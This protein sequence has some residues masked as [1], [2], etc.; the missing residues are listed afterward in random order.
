MDNVLVDSFVF[1]CCFCFFL[2][3]VVANNNKAW[4]GHTLHH[5]DMRTATSPGQWQQWTAVSSL[6]GLISEG[7][8]MWL[9]HIPTR[10]WYFS[11]A[12]VFSGANMK[13]PP[14]VNYIQVIPQ[15]LWDPQVMNSNGKHV[16]FLV[17]KS[18][19]YAVPHCVKS[20]IER[21]ENLRSIA[22]MDFS[23]TL[24]SDRMKRMT[25]F[26]RGKGKNTKVKSRARRIGNTGD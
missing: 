26:C 8:T 3:F 20:R 17:W 7:S 21:G 19:F 23:W 18:A 6:L 12:K 13:T 1:N 16:F 11:V 4:G 14:C 10:D 15:G 22:F 9:Y 5:S 24:L 25:A 2:I